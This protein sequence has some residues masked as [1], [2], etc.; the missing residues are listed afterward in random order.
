[1]TI[2]DKNE[3]VQ[4]KE[5]IDLKETRQPGRDPNQPGQTPQDSGDERF[6][7]GPNIFNIFLVIFVIT[8][9]INTLFLNNLRD[10]RQTIAYSQFLQ[11]VESGNLAEVQLGEEEVTFEISKNADQAELDQILYPDGRPENVALPAGGTVFT[12]VR[13]DDPQLI[14]RLT[15][16]KVPF[17]QVLNQSGSSPF[18]NF[19][20]YWVLPVV[21]MYLF[22]SFILRNAAK[23]MGGTMG[24]GGG[25]FG[26]GKSKA[27]EYNVEKRVDVK[28]S[29]VAGQDEAKESLMEM[30]DFL[31][32]PEKYTKIG[33]TQPKGALLVGPP[34]TGKT[35]LARAVAG[36]AGVPFYSIT[37]SEFVE[38]FVGVGA[39]RV[40][41]LFD[42]AKKNAPCIIFI[43]EIDAIGKSRDNALGSNDE[44]EQTLNQLLAEMDGFEGSEGIVVLAA[45]NRPE[46]L[47]K[48]LL[49]PGRFDRRIIV[50]KPDLKGRE[51][52]LLVHARKY[53]LGSDVQFREVALATSGA[54]GADLAN[55]LNEAALLAVKDG[56]EV[57]TQKDLLESVEVVIAGK[58]MKD[59]VMNSKE[60][61]MVSYHEVGHALVSAL[62][63]DGPPVTKITIVPRTMGSLGY[64][65]N[66]PEEERYLLTKS[67][68]LAQITSLLG[69]RAAEIVKFGEVTTG[70]SNDIERATKMARGMITQYG[71]SEKFGPMNLES[72]TNQYLD[73]RNVGNYSDETG[74]VIDTEVRKILASCQDNA[75]EMIKE[76]TA[77]L[78]RIAKFLL[79]KENI[80]GKEFMELLKAENV[81]VKGEVEVK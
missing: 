46:V 43:D 81:D 20:T 32:N 10:A 14:D 78:D 36:E 55:M 13:A 39:S 2:N 63:K 76:N 72:T 68:L 45:T 33:A 15:E 70:A 23:K 50:D 37:G 7:K 54:T 16:N 71:M 4:N 27:T 34:G 26:I 74:S 62:Q 64:T 52:I 65:M 40:R 49:R 24:S 9:I 31:K 66:V 22:Y 59:R 19:L 35:L 77:A 47:D 38:M 3:E 11:L 42:T 41:D 57:V 80:S 18:L 58:E 79:E 75:V 25:L 53:K 28:F 61:E 8:F 44:R 51:E 6:F 56:R 5:S 12:A 67:E 21:V 48:A 1:M 30:V 29:D 73:G 17:Y 60:R 69:G